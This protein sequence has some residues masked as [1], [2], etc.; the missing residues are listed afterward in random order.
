MSN[1]LKYRGYTAKINYSAEDNILF[2]KIEGIIALITFEAENVAEIATAFHDA[3][4]DYLVYCDENGIEPEK[5]YR[6]QFNVR[7]SPELHKSIVQQAM[8]EDI[9]LNKYVENALAY[10][11]NKAE[12]QKPFI[13]IN[14]FENKYKP[15][16]N[17]T[18]K[19]KASNASFLEGG[20]YLQ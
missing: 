12:H 2:G 14:H 6:G 18:T 7:I 5:E 17:W 20:K 15:N 1:V 4:D 8:F 16:S 11:S 13:Q 10:Y 3:V 19:T 9:S